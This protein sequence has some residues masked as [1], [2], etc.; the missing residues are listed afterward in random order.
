MRLPMNL[1]TVSTALALIGIGMA[2]GLGS[3]GYVSLVEGNPM[4]VSAFPFILAMLMLLVID[5]RSLFLLILLLRASGDIVFESSKFGGGFGVGGLINALVIFIALLFII[6]RPGVINRRIASIWGGVLLVALAAIF[7]APEFK[8]AARL[9]LALS[10]YCAVFVIAFYMVRTREDFERC[11]SAILLSSLLP[12]LYAFVDIALNAG[13]AATEEGFRLQSTFSH[14]NI[15][16]FY[17]V[18]NISL[19]FY[20]LKTAWQHIALP[21]KWLGYAYLLLLLALLVLTQTRSAWAACIIVFAVYGL[22]FERRYLLYLLLAPLL[23]LMMPSV[24][25]RLLDL[26]SGNEYVQYARLNS[27]AWRLLL[28]ESAL[29][30]MSP[31]KVAFGYGLN[32]FK[33]YSPVF[34]PLAGNTNFGAHSTYVQWFFE[35]GAVGV[36]ASAWMYLR[37]FFTLQAGFRQNR[38]HAVITITLLVEYLF[39]AFSDNMLDYLSFNWYFWFFIGS[40]VALT[41]ASKAEEKPE[42]HHKPT[43]TGGMSHAI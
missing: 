16:A 22:M 3:V 41:M 9:F 38:L 20:R 42:T 23:A 26:G 10:S 40:A 25:D 13:T 28:W 35:T 19:L 5:K 27:F 24:R 8:D 32:A 30:W 34:F 15:F 33:H 6:E 43:S 29:D 2:A 37:L 21:G 11:V 7:H 36:L 14:P 39:F 1:K 31:V 12:V 4:L 18:L 17:L